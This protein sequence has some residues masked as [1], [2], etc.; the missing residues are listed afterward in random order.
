[1]IQ[2]TCA[3]RADKSDVEDTLGIN[4][5]DRALTKPGDIALKSSTMK[6]AKY[7]RGA[8][9]T[10]DDGDNTIFMETAAKAFYKMGV[11]IPDM[12]NMRVAFNRDEEFVKRELMGDSNIIQYDATPQ[13]NANNIDDILD[14][15]D[16]DTTFSLEDLDNI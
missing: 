14:A 12:S 16:E 13:I 9:L 4:K 6:N 10:T 15:D 2:Y 11:E 5:W 7:V 8:A 1:M 3:V